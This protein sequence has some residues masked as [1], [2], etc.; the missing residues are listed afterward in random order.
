MDYDTALPAGDSV[1]AA[2]ST[3]AAASSPEKGGE[4]L[5]AIQTTESPVADGDRNWTMAATRALAQSWRK[6]SIE[7]RG[8]TRGRCMSPSASSP[9]TGG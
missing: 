4:Q 9:T 8:R 7:G 3:Q 2:R 6:V 5:V 1:V